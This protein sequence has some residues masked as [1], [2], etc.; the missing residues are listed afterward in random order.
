MMRELKLKPLWL[1]IGFAMV[2]FVIYS[3]LSTSPPVAVSFKLSDKLMH[4]LGYFGLM[5]WFMQIYQ[6]KKMQLILA[7]VFICM[8]VG[9]EFLQDLGGVRFF[10]IKDMVANSVG[11]LLAWSLV[12]TPFPQLLHYFESKVFS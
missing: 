9:L 4:M 7:V 12:K 5:G 3:S 2:F 8:G 6:N 11:V 1:A 10:E